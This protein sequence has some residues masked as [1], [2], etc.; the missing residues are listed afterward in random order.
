MK[1]EVRKLKRQVLLLWGWVLFLVV[2][3]IILAVWHY[4]SISLVNATFE[5]IFVAVKAIS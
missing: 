2:D 4:R 1:K 3:I 5:S